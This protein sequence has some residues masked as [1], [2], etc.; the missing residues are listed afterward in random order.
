VRFGLLGPLAVWTSPGERVS[1]PGAK[2]R[3]LL[4][5]LLVNEGR[6]VST[7]QLV[8]DLWG[9]RPPGK[10]AGT[11]QAKVSQL[12]RALE[13]AEP[14][15]R[16]LVVSVPPGY[17]VRPE[18]GAVDAARFAT[19]AHQ[20]RTTDDPGAR[21]AL[22][23]DALQLWRGPALADFGDEPFARAAI[24]RLEEERL[25]VLEEHAEA[26]LALGEH[27]QLAGELGQLVSRHPL[28][29]RLRAA[30]MRALYRA[31]RQ[32]EALASYG[33]LRD[34]LV[35][36][37]GLDPSPELVALHLA[38]LRHDPELD[39]PEPV[40]LPG[41]LP[42][43]FTDL[44]GRTEAVRE[45]RKQLESNRLVTLTG[46]GGVGK[47][48]LAVET[49]AHMQQTCPDGAW[50][51][52]LAAVGEP[53]G[54]D[55]VGS[56][57][58]AV[59]AT[60]GIREPAAPTLVAATEPVAAIDRLA[61]VLRPKRSLLVLDNCEHVVEPVAELTQRLLTAAPGLRILATSREP[62]GLAGE[63]LWTVPPLDVPGPDTETEP[64][65]L[66]AFSAVQLFVAR[67]AAAAPGFALDA[68]NA[69]A[70]AAICRRLDGIPLALELAATRVRGLG[71]HELTTRL[72]DRFRVLVSGHRG[73]PPRQQTLRA[74][75]DWSWDLLTG[76]E[77]TVLRRLALHPEGCDLDAAQEICG[78]PDVAETLARLVDRS[79]VVATDTT[80]G[81]RYRL[82]ESVAAY[83]AERLAEA[84]EVDAVRRRHYRYY[85]DLAERSQHHLRGDGQGEWLE[86]LDREAANL[87]GALDGAAEDEVA[88][89]ALRLVDAAAWYWFL[90]G[91]LMEARRAFELALAIDGDSPASTRARVLAWRAGFSLLIGDPVGAAG[92]HQAALA[93]CDDIDEPGKR[94]R[95]QWFLGF[96]TSDWGDLSTS[97]DLV[98]RALT[99]FR[100]LGDGWGIA[101][102]LSTWAK[103]AHNRGDLAAVRRDSE[104]SLQLFRDLGDRWG[105]IQATEWLGAHAI[106][107]GD[108]DLAARLY[109][110][111]HRMAEELG[112][113][114]EA[115]DQLSWLGRITLLTGDAAQARALHERAMR[116]AADHG[117]MPGAG[118]AEIGLAEA[119]RR[120]GDLDA[121]ERHLRRVLDHVRQTGLETGVADVLILAQLG[122][123]AE[124]RGE[125]AAA[126]ALHLDAF[127]I[128]RKLGDPRALAL[129][130]EGLAGAQ[131]L[132]GQHEHAAH[133]L[134]AATA[135]RE[136]AGAPLP[137]AERIDVDRITARL[138]TALGEADF[139]AAFRRGSELDPDD[140]AALAERL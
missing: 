92:Q 2:V 27:S 85:T 13:E 97:E 112:L 103:Q 42:T 115:A 12:R 106:A 82:L 129:A 37:L 100:A 138:R 119:A 59:S 69:P 76:P 68:T 89:L 28:R 98:D 53:G 51:V 60:L 122:F 118:F 5:D 117:Y 99:A 32:S 52:E 43:A 7:G 46:S 109:R 81:P 16:D 95:A 127:A 111:G 136:S 101:A 80:T 70:V 128:A 124:Q 8:D 137:P 133:L 66:S 93:L 64:D 15:A 11:L 73:A 55:G 139:A 108:N 86:R 17:L 84:G 31:G 47:T 6:P 10:P 116:L 96:A 36:D 104:E 39:A 135:A 123:V 50:L 18:P 54:A 121:A 114:P 56:L 79:L 71:V 134:G 72:D 1:V 9:D 35:E 25:V 110:E 49:A 33:Q 78:D 130:L 140:L 62:L 4:A 125:A 48:R 41:N 65:G 87:R 88:D 131:A 102:A 21:C 23:A 19:L 94:A 44:V 45:V 3:A 24:T 61:D 40:R 58:A 29:E 57:A 26:R 14:G 132:A 83:G 63:I 74:V 91:R 30:H 34:Q 107:T 105:Q 20:A 113:W 22:L 120:Q 90:R 126:G 77:R 38:I 67:A 75:I